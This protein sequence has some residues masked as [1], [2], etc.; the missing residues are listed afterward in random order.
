MRT[1][2]KPFPPDTPVALT[3]LDADTRPLLQARVVETTGDTVLVRTPDR[4]PAGAPVRLERN[5][6][7]LLGEIR[8]VERDGDEWVLAVQIVHSLSSL[9]ELERF[10]RALLGERTPRASLRT[11]PE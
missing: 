10:N 11:T 8:A 1:G 3:V 7:L 9:A 4:I 6:T 2:V 5:D